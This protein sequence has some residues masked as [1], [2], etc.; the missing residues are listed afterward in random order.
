MTRNLSTSE[1]LSDMNSTIGEAMFAMIGTP[2]SVMELQD[3]YYAEGLY[4]TTAQYI[5]QTTPPPAVLSCP[6]YKAPNHS[7]VTSEQGTMF[8][9]MTA[10]I[11]C[12]NRAKLMGNG[13][14]VVVCQSDGT[15]SLGRWCQLCEAG[16]VV[17]DKETCV[18][19][20]PGKFNDGTLG[21][22][23]MC[24]V[25]TYQEHSG[26]TSCT[27]CPTGAVTSGRPGSKALVECACATGSYGTGVDC[28]VCPVGKYSNRPG[29]FRC[30]ECPAFRNTSEVDSKSASQC[31]CIH[32]Y[33]QITE[34]SVCS[35]CMDGTFK[36]SL[37][38]HPC[39]QCPAS[40]WTIGNGTRLEVDCL[41]NAGY[42]VDVSVISAR[43]CTLC[44]QGKYKRDFRQPE[45]VECPAGTYSSVGQTACINCPHG[46]YNEGG[47]GSCLPCG[48]GTYIVSPGSVCLECAAGTYLNELGSACFTCSIGMESELPKRSKT[49]KNCI[50]GFSNPSQGGMCM[51]CPAGKQSSGFQK[52][53][54]CT[55][56]S[57]GKYTSSPGKY[58]CTDCAAGRYSGVMA[59]VC[60][61]CQQGTYSGSQS[62]ACTDCPPGTYNDQLQQSSCALCAQNTYM[63]YLGKTACYD[64]PVQS[65]T[66]GTGA[67][68]VAK[69]TCDGGKNMSSDRACVKYW[70]TG[71]VH[72]VPEQDLLNGG[73]QKC[74][75]DKPYSDGTLTRQD[76]MCGMSNEQIKSGRRFAF[77]AM[78]RDGSSTIEILAMGTSRVSSG[79]FPVFPLPLIGARPASSPK[80]DA[81]G[82]LVSEPF[83]D[84]AFQPEPELENGVYWYVTAKTF[85]FSSNAQVILSDYDV[86]S[87]QCED[88][89]GWAF[90]GPGHRVGCRCSGCTVDIDNSEWD[91]VMYWL[92]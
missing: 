25:D 82:N 33:Y 49:C 21:Y 45:C 75:L 1:S 44:P 12:I 8:E 19:C 35:P 72:N 68:S 46:K 76:L 24:P 51:A 39:Q 32:G 47:S 40:S 28:Q 71:V 9:G 14:D 86:A 62:S 3:L 54:G 37:G 81:A 23:S 60:G 15:Y 4:G 2:V 56:C 78:R 36:N 5:V 92:S 26:Q 38:N 90:G 77:G 64:C 74:S 91:R 48:G 41:C 18:A 55:D 11:T 22:C 6:P 84:N 7:T 80:L 63:D 31:L 13:S 79:A 30:Y 69:C 65:A 50:P 67:D 73:W 53:T 61:T 17:Q 66:L 59:S 42:E 58:E 52:S 89:L 57:P 43:I 88:R 83:E 10:K 34:E 27:A 16:K 29:L 20:G 85:G 87:S 70:R